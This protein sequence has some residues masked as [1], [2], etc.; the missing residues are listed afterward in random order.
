VVTVLA[1]HRLG[2]AAVAADQAVTMEGQAAVA[3]WVLLGVT[4]LCLPQTT[5]LPEFLGVGELLAVQVVLGHLSYRAPVG[6]AARGSM[7]FVVVAVVVEYDFLEQA[8]QLDQVAAATED[9]NLQ[10]VM[11]RRQR[12]TLAQAAGVLIAK[13]QMIVW[14]KLA[15]PALCVSG[16]LNKENKNELCTHQQ[17][18]S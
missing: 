2:L 14:E 13:V 1:L 5:L 4:P 11:L 15:A 12:P 7:G 6:L 3:A 18:H 9:F 16:G 10:V 17:Q 8:L